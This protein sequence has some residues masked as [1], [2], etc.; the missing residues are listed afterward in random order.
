MEGPIFLDEACGFVSWALVFLAVVLVGAPVGDFD[1]EALGRSRGGRLWVGGLFCDG[2]V[3]GALVDGEVDLLAGRRCDGE[4]GVVY[5]VVQGMWSLGGPRWGLRETLFTAM[6][7]RV[8]HIQ[9]LSMTGDS[10]QFTQ[11]GERIQLIK[12]GIDSL[13]FHYFP[14]ERVEPIGS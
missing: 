2:P 9:R 6:R 7:P 8:F 5:Q 3:F 4:E 13:R 1:E 11:D 12:H 10:F 14:F